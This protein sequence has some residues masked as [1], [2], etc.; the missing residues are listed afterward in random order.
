MALIG[1]SIVLFLFLLFIFIGIGI[2]SDTTDPFAAVVNAGLT[3]SAGIGIC[4]S[5]PLFVHGVPVCCAFIHFHNRAHFPH[6]TQ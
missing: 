1:S 3:I 6:G 2:F 5:L 4:L